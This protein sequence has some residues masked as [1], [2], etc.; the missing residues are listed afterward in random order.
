MTAEKIRA[1]KWMIYVLVPVYQVILLCLFIAGTE[2]YNAFTV[3]LGSILLIF[4]V[5]IDFFLIR[6]VAYMV[7]KLTK[8]EQLTELYAQRQKKLEYYEKSEEYIGQMREIRHEFT[9][10]L[11]TAYAMLEQ[12]ASRKEVKE[13]LDAAYNRLQE[14]TPEEQGLE[15]QSATGE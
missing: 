14:T 15:D 11:Q 5:I 1:R 7:E 2:E 8:E 9:N 6:S 10:Q 13:L 12:G 3:I 4:S